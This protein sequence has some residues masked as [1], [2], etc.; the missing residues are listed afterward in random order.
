MFDILLLNLDLNLLSHP[1]LQMN[2]QKTTTVLFSSTF[3]DSQLEYEML[4]N[5]VLPR[6]NKTLIKK[7]ARV[8]C[9][10]LPWIYSSCES[11]YQREN[12]LLQDI[13]QS[14]VTMIAVTDNPEMLSRIDRPLEEKDDE[15]IQAREAEYFVSGMEICLKVLDPPQPALEAFFYLCVPS[16]GVESTPTEKT[17]VH[18]TEQ[19]QLNRFREIERQLLDKGLKV[20]EYPE[21]EIE[22]FGLMIEA[23][24]RAVIERELEDK[25]TVRVRRQSKEAE[26]EFLEKLTAGQM[27]EDRW[28]QLF[29]KL[30][31]AYVDAL[32]GYVASRVGNIDDARDI[33][34]EVFAIAFE[35]IR[36]SYAK[37]QI[38][39]DEGGGRIDQETLHDGFVHLMRGTD[40]K[41][42]R[43]YPWL[44][45]IA[46]FSM[47]NYH[48]KSRAAHR[49]TKHEEPIVAADQESSL[50]VQELLKSVLRK[51][52]ANKRKIVKLALEGMSK[53]EIA[54]SEGLELRQ[55]EVMLGG[56]KRQV[57]QILSGYDED[58]VRELKS[59]IANQIIDRVHFL[60][61]APLAVPAAH[62]FVIDVWAYFQRQREQVLQR[63]REEAAGEKLRMKSK[64][65]VKV[66]RGTILKVRLNLPGFFIE[67]PEDTILWEGEI[68]NASFAA[69]VPENAGYGPRNGFVAIYVDGL[70]IARLAFTI[71][72]NQELSSSPDV[73]SREQRYH[74]AFASHADEDR[75]AVLA[76]IQ[77]MQKIAPDLDVF[78]AP[79][80]LR[81]G[82][83]W[84][85][86]LRQ[87]I[88][89]RDVMYL[90]W[91]EAASKSKWV[92][93][94]W[95]CGLRE[96]GIDY[97]DPVPLVSPEKVPPPKELIERLHFDDW[98]LAYMRGTQINQ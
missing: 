64:G 65:P 90:F 33:V 42:P 68:A 71:R 63:I 75:D 78:I 11:G 31:N 38:V 74:T 82:E 28:Q 22:K 73:I 16:S 58:D 46:K 39:L 30:Y 43:F 41:Q 21:G 49:P 18:G 70:E 93:W 77:G 29:E 84:Q 96:R 32:T 76:R 4:E 54:E 37:V 61:T 62:S 79:A 56:A 81:S 59:E 67:Q 98:L 17:N 2:D 80:K 23:D 88:L 27:D 14:R 72:I 34:Q 20:S 94:E 51:L 44:R 53:K 9:V 83:N 19:A 92:D 10:Q 47:L 8:E 45:N 6:L 40:T 89:E 48:R 26:I 95:R 69:S 13:T 15:V 12:E 3:V 25:S 85:E 55:V 5:K 36:K 60:T 86:R 91:S 97:I 52:P 35:R 50:H 1:S 87:E 24:I 57:N 7:G 66:A